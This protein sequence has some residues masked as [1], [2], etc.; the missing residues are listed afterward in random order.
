M[1]LR[2]NYGLNGSVSLHDE[3]FRSEPWFGAWGR[4]V[5]LW[6][7]D[8]GLGDGRDLDEAVAG[9]RQGAQVKSSSH[10]R[11]PYLPSLN[12]HLCSHPL[13]QHL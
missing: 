5:G 10:H 1:G 13:T 8:M 11:P 9:V 3:R 12:F 7:D 2:G 4:F 6:S